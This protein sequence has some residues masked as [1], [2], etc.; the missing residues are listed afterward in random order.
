MLIFSSCGPVLLSL[1]LVGGVLRPQIIQGRSHLPVKKMKDKKQLALK[2]KV[3]V[4]L[5]CWNGMVQWGSSK[6]QQKW[7]FEAVFH[8]VH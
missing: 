8:A 7:Q 3:E 1:L 5:A 2:Q 4:V 6:A